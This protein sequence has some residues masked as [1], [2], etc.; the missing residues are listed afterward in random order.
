MLP[1]Q[2]SVWANDAGTVFDDFLGQLKESK[3]QAIT[4][5]SLGFLVYQD[6]DVL[7]WCEN[8]TLPPELADCTGLKTVISRITLGAG[9]K[10]IV[11]KFAETRGLELVQDAHNH[12]YASNYGGEDPAFDNDEYDDEGVDDEDDGGMGDEHD[13][14]MDDEHDESD[15]SD[16]S[17][18]SDDAEE[19]SDDSEY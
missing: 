16:E 11:R 14:G 1:Y 3:K 8:W 15:A 2:L 6:S 12:G 18:N 5:I 17:E 10:R 13:E 9:Q 4:T 7:D 19:D